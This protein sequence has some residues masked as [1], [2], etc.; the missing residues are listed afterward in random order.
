MLTIM[1][2]H[3]PVFQIPRGCE[4]RTYVTPAWD[5]MAVRI[6]WIEIGSDE[7]K[8]FRQRRRHENFFRSRNSAQ[9]FGRK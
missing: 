9:T 5:S 8:L 3:Y 1:M 2:A 4:T 7:G 6:S